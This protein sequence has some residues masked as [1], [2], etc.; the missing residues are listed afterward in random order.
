MAFVEYQEVT[1]YSVCDNCPKAG[2]GYIT[3]GVE[4]VTL[5]DDCIKSAIDALTT[6]LSWGKEV[7]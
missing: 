1:T 4:V 7:S 5:C 2:S 3:F 6:I